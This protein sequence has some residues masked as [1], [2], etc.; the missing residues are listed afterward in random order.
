MFPYS[1]P[2]RTPNFRVKTKTQK[3]TQII[4][5]CSNHL[6]YWEQPV[7]LWGSTWYVL[8]TFVSWGIYA[9]LV[10]PQNLAKQS[11]S[12]TTSWP[13]KRQ[14]PWAALSWIKIPTNCE[15][16]SHLVGTQCSL[17]LWFSNFFLSFLILEFHC[18]FVVLQLEKLEKIIFQIGKK[19]VLFGKIFFRVEQLLSDFSTRKDRKS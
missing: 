5:I 15:R 6:S 19:N 18:S 14:L 11:I 9:W 1:L 2:S 16:R 3:K 10:F 4:T 7:H 8:V 17:W 13:E 12:Q